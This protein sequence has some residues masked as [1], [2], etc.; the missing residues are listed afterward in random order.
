MRVG[1]RLTDRLINA[2][3]DGIKREGIM[4]S[5]MC[6]FDV[7]KIM[8]RDLLCLTVA[9]STNFF[10]TSY[11]ADNG[12]HPCTCVY[13][14]LCV[15]LCVFAYIYSCECVCVCLCMSLS[16]CVLCVCVRLRGF[17]W[18]CLYLF[19]CACVCACVCLCACI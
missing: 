10:T 16:V 3:T 4:A 15:L 14:C 19:V 1:G 6:C 7:P 18:A 13:M 5:S 11:P 12:S 9:T 17:V 2:T 8:R